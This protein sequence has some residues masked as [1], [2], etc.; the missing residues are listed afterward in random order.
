M[1]IK[2]KPIKA[3]VADRQLFNA[4]F[5]HDGALLIAGSYQGDLRRFDL[6]SEENKELKSINGH[7]AW[8]QAFDLHPSNHQIISG[9]SW[10]KLQ[11]HD[12][13]QDN[14]VPIWALENAHDGWIRSIAFSKTGDWFATC[15]LDQ[16]VRVF[17]AKNGK[18]KQVLTGH[19]ADI[20]HVLIHPE[21]D[22]LLSADA[23]GNVIQWDLKKR[24]AV[25]SFDATETF[26]SHRLQD[27]GGVQC[28]TFSP[29]GKT[30][31]VGG[32]RPK[33]GATVQGVPIIIGFSWDTTEQT[34]LREIGGTADCYC[35]DLKF[36]PDGFLMAVTSGTPGTGKL[37]FIDL[38]QDEPSFLL[39]NL[40]NC[41]SL[42]IHPDGKTIA[43][44]TT[45]RGSNGNGRKVDADGNYIGNNSPIQILVP[46]L[47]ES[48]EP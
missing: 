29:D 38:Q 24:R 39:S 8:V 11:L 42:D 9:D 4:R 10:G 25:R 40:S 1:N 28:L 30:L 19:N 20:Y 44:T 33:N 34:L 13:T 12:Y 36:H 35:E 47:P 3:P 6:T 43:V 15:G 37:Q 18:E 21:E 14:P 46:D 48:A 27:V 7:H 2:Y 17:N 5:S 31:Y 22:Q 26:L 16:T 32:T 23:L 41:H 45:V